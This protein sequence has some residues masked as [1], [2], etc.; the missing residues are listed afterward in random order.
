MNLQ[1]NKTDIQAL[2]Q[3]LSMLQAAMKQK[4]IIMYIKL[5]AA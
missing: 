4:K 1:C 3:I 5:L 2:L